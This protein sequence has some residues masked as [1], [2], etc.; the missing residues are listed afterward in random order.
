MP[1]ARTKRRLPARPS[2]IRYAAH[3]S[4]SLSLSLRLYARWNVKSIREAVARAA[5]DDSR[6][7]ER[8]RRSRTSIRLICPRGQRTASFAA[9]CIS[10]PRIP[11]RVSGPYGV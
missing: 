11:S 2:L 3:L 6:V 4:L 9:A 1:L 8:K 7:E 5:N 10:G